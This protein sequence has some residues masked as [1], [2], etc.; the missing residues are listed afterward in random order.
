M[1]SPFSYQLRASRN[2]VSSIA[3]CAVTHF[4]QNLRLQVG[5]IWKSKLFLLAGEV[6]LQQGEGK[7]AHPYR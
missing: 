3:A 4:G 1:E 5:A 7:D 2:P 6:H